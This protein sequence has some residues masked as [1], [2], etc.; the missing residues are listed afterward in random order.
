[1]ADT[2]VADE[3]SDVDDSQVDESGSQEVK[4]K[5]EKQSPKTLTPEL[6][7]MVE[8]LAQDRYTE[9]LA[10]DGDV[11]K[12]L[13]DKVEKQSEFIQT[14]QDERL[15]ETAEKYG[16]SL[17]DV[18]EAGITDPNKIKA[19]AKIFGKS[20]GEVVKPPRVDS[21]ANSG[22]SPSGLNQLRADYAGGK[23][24]IAEYEKG[25]EKYK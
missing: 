19:L 7:K 24:G 22:G 21:G 23:I 5:I 15:A 11:A 18:K 13:E 2:K 17:D 10:K 8:K 1:M 9:K 16:L 14:L 25:L 20:E 4:P 6:K 3:T 12:I